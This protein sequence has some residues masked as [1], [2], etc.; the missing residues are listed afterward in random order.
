MVDKIKTDVDRYI[1]IN[2]FF[3]HYQNQKQSIYVSLYL[4]CH[5]LNFGN[6]ILCILHTNMQKLDQIVHMNFL[7]FPSITCPY[8]A[9]DQP[10]HVTRFLLY[11]H[12]SLCILIS[13]Q[14]KTDNQKFVQL[15]NIIFRIKCGKAY[16]NAQAS[17]DG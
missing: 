10:G 9:I 8:K 16:F 17:R 13:I 14:I 6:K 1:L 4:L 11:R 15:N 5:F 7:I 3:F 2:I 12:L